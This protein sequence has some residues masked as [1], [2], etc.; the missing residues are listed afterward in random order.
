MRVA[1]NFWHGAALTVSCAALLGL[2]RHATVSAFLPL[3]IPPPHTHSRRHQP[4]PFQPSKHQAAPLPL[5]LGLFLAVALLVLYPSLPDA[6]KRLAIILLA[7]VVLTDTDTDD[8]EAAKPPTALYLHKVAPLLLCLAMANVFTL[9]ALLAPL[10]P[11]AHPA[12]ALLEARAKVAALKGGM[13]AI[14]AGCGRAF[15]LGEEMHFSTIEQVG[16]GFG[17][18]GID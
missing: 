8:N 2:V 6:G 4:P 3:R 7:L 5:L 1:C 11:Y 17:F 13:R 14:V 15:D 16:F 18:W 9:L 10:P 12:L